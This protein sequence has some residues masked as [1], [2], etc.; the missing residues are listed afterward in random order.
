MSQNLQSNPSVQVRL[1]ARRQD[2]LEAIDVH[3][4]HRSD[5]ATHLRT[6]RD[7]TDDQ[8][9]VGAMDAMEI[10]EVAR[11]GDELS[12]VD[13]AL[14]RLAQGRYGICTGCG[15]PVGTARLEASPEA[16][17]CLACQTAL[18]RRP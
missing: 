4:V 1:N 15:E 8:A 2:L 5:G 13:A 6:H 18:E 16:A 14:G 17:L 12:A 11:L 9:V 10:G 7:E 3:K